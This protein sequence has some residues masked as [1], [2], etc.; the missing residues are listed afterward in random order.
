M[1]FFGPRCTTPKLELR[2][3]VLVSAQSRYLLLCLL[4]SVSTE[5]LHVLNNST[6]IDLRVAAL[7]AL[8]FLS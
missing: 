4:K 5:A 1:D 7:I 3:P 2:M 6:P 8:K